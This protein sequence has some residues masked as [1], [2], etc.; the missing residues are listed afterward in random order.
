MSA[1]L[2]RR[3]L[4]AGFEEVWPQLTEDIQNGV[5]QQLMLAIQEELTPPVRRKI[6]DAAAELARNMI[7]WFHSSSVKKIDI[8]DIKALTF[9]K[10]IIYDI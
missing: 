1:V 6:C 3:L 2:L 4:A 8:T 10:T 9:V 7:G 5:K